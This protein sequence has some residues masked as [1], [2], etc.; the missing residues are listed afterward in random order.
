[1]VRGGLTKVAEQYV[2]KG[3]HIAIVGKLRV[4]S[5]ESDGKKKMFVTEIHVDELE[6]LDKKAE[7]SGSTD[8]SAHPYTQGSP[9]AEPPSDNLPF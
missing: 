8:N 3:S 4:R 2:K 7:S 5:Y 6:L 1:M 9:N